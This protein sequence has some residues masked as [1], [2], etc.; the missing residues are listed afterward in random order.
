MRSDRVCDAWRT[1]DTRPRFVLPNPLTLVLTP[2]FSGHNKQHQS[3]VEPG[4]F[5]QTRA[6]RH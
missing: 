4:S 6:F 2:D 5:G 3:R 1:S